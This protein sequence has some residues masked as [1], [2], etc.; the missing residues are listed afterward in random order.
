LTVEQLYEQEVWRVYA[1]F[2]YRTG[3]RADAEDLTQATFE[4]AIRAFR[5][6]DPQRASPSTWLLAIA[7]NLLI[8]HHRRK[9]VRRSDPVDP[10]V[11]SELAPAHD[12]FAD[13]GMRPD[14]ATALATLTDRER[15]FVALRYGADLT[16]PEI[17]ELTGQSLANVQQI[18]SRTL[19]KL[20]AQL[21]PDAAPREA[22]PLSA[23]APSPG[24]R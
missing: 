8:D 17:A 11:L 16:G 20:R 4:R 9:T 22:E 13:L 21:G 24:R 14:L 2:A 6:Y 7:G 10:Q 23:P 18:L 19:R 5:R 1:F 3:S 12:P 15:T